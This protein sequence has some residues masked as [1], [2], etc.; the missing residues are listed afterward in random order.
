MTPLQVSYFIHSHPLPFLWTS[1]R[2][3]N[4]LFFLATSISM[5]F[6]SSAAP[7]SLLSSSNPAKMN[8]SRNLHF[9]NTQCTLQPSI[10]NAKSREIKNS[11][12]F[13]NWHSTSVCWS[14]RVYS[15]E[16]KSHD[17]DKKCTLLFCYRS[18]ERAWGRS[19]PQLQTPPIPVRIPFSRY[20]FSLNQTT[21]YQLSLFPSAS[22]SCITAAASLHHNDGADGMKLPGNT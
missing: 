18:H 16:W 1:V 3:G 12:R 15:M 17:T 8:L 9:M 21:L 19:L 4:C 10:S 22:N 11:C 2:L 6:I 14:T 7:V 5:S 20:I 13:G